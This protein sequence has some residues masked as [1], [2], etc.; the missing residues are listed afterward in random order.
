MLDRNEDAG[1]V[2]PEVET[3]STVAARAGIDGSVVRRALR[4]GVLAGWKVGNTWIVDARDADRW[5]RTRKRGRPPKR[6]KQLK[7][8]LEDRGGGTG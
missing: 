2:A 8:G 3:T 4:A 1:Q 5:I 6:P 7:I